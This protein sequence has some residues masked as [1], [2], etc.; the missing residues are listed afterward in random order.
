MS[1][2]TPGRA[3]VGVGRLGAGNMSFENV[4]WGMGGA[5]SFVFQEGQAAVRVA[6]GKVGG[7]ETS[8]GNP[9]KK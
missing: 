3:N 1:T 8:A 4:T 9:D 2:P 6:K 7:S 5:I